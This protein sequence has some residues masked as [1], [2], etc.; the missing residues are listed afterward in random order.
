MRVH[1]GFQIVELVGKARIVLP[2]RQERQTVTQPAEKLHLSR[3]AEKLMR[4][5]EVV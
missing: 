5:F 3:L 2:A 1:I 4:V